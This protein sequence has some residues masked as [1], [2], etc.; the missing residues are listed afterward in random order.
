MKAIPYVSFNGNC[1]E[2]IQFYHSILG[3]KIEILRYK[4]LPAEEGIPI[5]EKWKDKILHSSIVF[6]G[7][8]CLYFGDT[9]ENTSVELGSNYTIHLQVN[10]EE[11]V[12][13]FVKLLGINGNITMPADRTFWNSIYGSLIDKFGISWGLEFEIKK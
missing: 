7:G 13:R 3:G 2:A 1:E 9:W 8:N 11:E 5:S 4:D 10:S 12:Y 6:E